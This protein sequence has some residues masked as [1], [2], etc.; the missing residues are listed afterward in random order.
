MS[1]DLIYDI[2]RRGMCL[3]FSLTI[4]TIEPILKSVVMGL[5]KDLLLFTFLCE[6]CCS[7]RDRSL[8]RSW[9]LEY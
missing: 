8:E 9:H 1:L 6:V 3:D 7:I 5:I 2:S 4:Y